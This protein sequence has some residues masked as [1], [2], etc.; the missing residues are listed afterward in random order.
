MNEMLVTIQEYVQREES[1]M[2]SPA[3][4]LLFGIIHILFPDA[5]RC[6]TE[7]ATCWNNGFPVYSQGIRR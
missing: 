3:D 2:L 7:A 6:G 4:G 5:R 1:S